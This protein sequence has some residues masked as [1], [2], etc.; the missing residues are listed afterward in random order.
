MPPSTV[1]PWGGL[2]TVKSRVI[3]PA[4]LRQQ[5]MMLCGLKNWNVTFLGLTNFNHPITGKLSIQPSVRI[6]VGGRY[7]GFSTYLLGKRRIYRSNSWLLGFHLFLL[8]T[9]CTA[10]FRGSLGSNF[11]DLLAFTSAPVEKTEKYSVIRCRR[12]K[13]GLVFITKKTP[14]ES[15]SALLVIRKQ[16][17][18]GHSGKAREIK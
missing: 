5:P 12:K 17:K 15:W 8:C 9:K 6:Y 14:W 13:I 1:Q 10:C 3:L 16:D 7:S 11:F 4:F 2:N 18:I